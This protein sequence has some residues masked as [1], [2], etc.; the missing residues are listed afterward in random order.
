MPPFEFSPSPDRLILKL[1]SSHDLLVLPPG[2]TSVAFNRVSVYNPGWPGPF[3]VDEAGL[4]LALIL[5]LNFLHARI[6][7]VFCHLKSSSSPHNASCSVLFWIFS[8]ISIP[9][10]RLLLFCVP[11]SGVQTCGR[12]LV[13][14]QDTAKW[15]FSVPILEHTV[16]T[17]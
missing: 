15:R 14:A 5:A 17:K 13:M 3:Y 9:C 10:T 16:G 1:L 2:S 11:T 6:T 7:C 8:A 12:Y 4:K